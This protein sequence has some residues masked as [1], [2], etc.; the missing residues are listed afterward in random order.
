MDVEF[1]T[2]CFSVY[3]VEGWK[4]GKNQKIENDRKVEEYKRFIFSLICV[5]V[6]RIAKWRDEKIFYLV[7]KKNERIE[8]IICINLPL[9]TNLVKQKIIHHIFINKLCP[10]D[11]FIKKKLRI[12]SSRTQNIFLKKKKKKKPKQLR[13]ERTSTKEKKTKKHGRTQINKEEK[14]RRANRI[15]SLG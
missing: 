8:N 13:K 10:N 6:G 9:C 2:S 1:T 15:W 5:L 12:R 4:S 7:E 14:D 11:Y 3:L